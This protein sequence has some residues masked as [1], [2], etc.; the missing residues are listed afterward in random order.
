MMNNEDQLV[1]PNF[2]RKPKTKKTQPQ[3]IIILNESQPLHS[4]RH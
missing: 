4:A 2:K 3:P 1:I